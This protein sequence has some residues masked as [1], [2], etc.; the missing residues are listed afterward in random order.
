MSVEKNDGRINMQA[1]TGF[2]PDGRGYYE[3]KTDE[4]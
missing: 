4:I 1:C 3:K 2:L